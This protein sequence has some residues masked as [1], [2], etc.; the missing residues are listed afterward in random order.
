MN[1][2]MVSYELPPNSLGEKDPITVCIGQFL[3]TDIRATL[4]HMNCL[5]I[6][7]EKRSITVCIG[8]FLFTDIIHMLASG[9]VNEEIDYN[10]S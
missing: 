3:F 10:T 5:Q 8:Q 4:F 7:W 6:A 9:L 1:R 2:Y